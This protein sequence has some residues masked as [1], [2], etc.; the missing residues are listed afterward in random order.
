MAYGISKKDNQIL[1]LKWTLSFTFFS[2]EDIIIDTLHQILKLQPPT[3]WCGS[4][5]Q[6]SESLTD[7]PWYWIVNT[8]DGSVTYNTENKSSH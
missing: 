2:R 5:L 7:L 3:I 4:C 1:T 6:I 8:L